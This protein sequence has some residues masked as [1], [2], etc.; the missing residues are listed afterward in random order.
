VNKTKKFLNVK[1]CGVNITALPER[2]NLLGRIGKRKQAT[3][4]YCVEEL[5]HLTSLL[6]ARPVYDAIST[7]N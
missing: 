7:S 2:F 1:C 3:F 6:L 4:S 5:A